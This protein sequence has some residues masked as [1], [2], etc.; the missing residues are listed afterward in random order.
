MT[1]RSFI[2]D[3][4]NIPDTIELSQKNDD[5]MDQTEIITSD[6]KIITGIWLRGDGKI[7]IDVEE[8]LK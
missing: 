4:L 6:G 2:F 7:I 5:P 8:S 1:L 3:I